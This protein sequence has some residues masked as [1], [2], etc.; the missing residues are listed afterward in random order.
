MA[1]IARVHGTALVPGVSRNGRLYTPDLIEK[2]VKRVQDRISSPDGMPITTRTHH[3][4]DDDSVKLVGHVTEM[5]LA[6]DGSAKYRAVITDTSEGRTIA[7]LLADHD[8]KPVLKGVSIR[9]AWLGPVRRQQHDGRAVETA[10]DLEIAGLDY[11]ATP[12]VPGAQVDGVEPVDV[13]E[14]RES[15][16]GGRTP[17]TESVQETLV[18][19]IQEAGATPGGSSGGGDDKKPYGDVAYADPGYQKDKKKRYPVDT[20]AHAKAAWSYVSQPDNAKLYTSAQLKRVKQRI[21]A[22]LKKFGVQIAAEEGWLIEPAVAVTESA[23]LAEYYG[24]DQQGSI[25][26]CLTNGPVTISVCSYCV[27]PHDLELIGRAAMDGACQA[28]LAI[29]PDLDGDMD[30]PGAPAEDRDNDM[31]TAPAG[32]A[33]VGESNEPAAAPAPGPP[34]AAV[35]GPLA[36]A[37]AGTEPPAP[38]VDA[39]STHREEP[40]VSEPTNPAADAVTPQAPAPV[41]AGITFTPEQFAALMDR[42]APAPVAAAA[43]SAPAPVAL[44]TETAPAAPATPVQP[45]ATPA[46]VAQAAPAAPAAVAETDDQRITRLVAEG[47]KAALPA[48]VQE[49]VERN[50]P[51]TRKGLVAPVTE[52]GPA[53]GQATGEGLN[54]H[55]LP[56]GW[57]DKPLHQYTDD[58]RAACFGPAL[59]QY[60]LG[61]R[62]DQ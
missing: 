4:A 20:K 23:A 17:I 24:M 59:E 6:P 54:S 52:T 36:P 45:A 11:T 32:T 30:V 53:T 34:P 37:E 51:P 62:A 16:D 9:G 39:G 46:P 35:A 38:P 2:A 27:D 50:G 1:V 19:N 8:G 21:K 31:A 12:G 3:A 40:A 10:D 43:E 58:E 13:P 61:A 25:S 44:A 22:A 18:E 33:P 14:P 5:T 48:A 41:P 56:Q 55:G 47:I 26:I 42:L 29:D 28:L 49:H 60:V 57:P 15:L 7:G